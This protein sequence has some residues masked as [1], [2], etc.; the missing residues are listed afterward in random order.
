MSNPGRRV[1]VV[2]DES[3]IRR[4]MQFALTA[5][6]YEPRPFVSGQDFLDELPHLSPGCVLLDI[7]MPEMNGLQVLSAMRSGGMR[8]PVIVMTG[9]GDVATAVEA[10]KL[11][12][13][14]FLEKPFAENAVL[15]S[16]QMLSKRLSEWAEQDRIRAEARAKLSL[17]NSRELEVLQGLIAGYSNKVIAQKLPLSVRTVEAYRA[18]LMRKLQISSVA[19]LV[20]LGSLVN[21]PPLD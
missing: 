13:D 10:M 4:S 2:D 21:L 19:E 18:D 6:G 5:A 14:D 20:R 16:L 7:R 3:N 9:H 12:A 11:G 17:L 15:S 8:F 1:Y